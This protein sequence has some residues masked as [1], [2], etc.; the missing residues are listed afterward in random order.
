MEIIIVNEKDTPLSSWGVYSNE[1][2]KLIIPRIGE[3]MQIEQQ[4]YIVF[5]VKYCMKYTY[6]GPPDIIYIYVKKQ[7]ENIKYE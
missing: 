5:N 4:D 1:A 6:F 7:N 3:S 2:Y